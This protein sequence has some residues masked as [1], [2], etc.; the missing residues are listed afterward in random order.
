MSSVVAHWPM[1]GS[2][3]ENPGTRDTPVCPAR[4]RFGNKLAEVEALGVISAAR[5]QLGGLRA[6]DVVRFAAH[7]EKCRDGT[8]RVGTLGS[9]T[10]S[11][12]TRTETPVARPCISAQITHRV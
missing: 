10:R 9:G 6:A 12:A 7:A 1:V 8:P 5:P 4:D 11:P 2:I 3:Y